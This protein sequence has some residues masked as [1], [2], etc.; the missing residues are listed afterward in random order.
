MVSS[1]QAYDSGV[2]TAGNPLAGHPWYVDRDRGSWFLA[3]RGIHA[4]AAAFSSAANN[5]MGKTF[6][7]MYVHPRQAVFNYIKRADTAEPGSIPFLNLA[8]IENPSCPYTAF[9]PGFSEKQVD[10]YIRQF[11]LGLGASRVMIILETDKLTTT[12][13]LPKWAQ[14]RRFRELSLEVSTLHRDDPNAIVY[15]D[16]G[17]WDWGKPAP[18]IARWLKRADVAQAEGFSLNT[19]HHDWTSRE[20]KFGLAISRMTGGKHFVVN[21]DSNAWGPRPHGKDFDSRYYVKGC[22]PP[23]EGLGIQPTVNTGNPL[24]DAYIWAGT[25]GY[26]TG[27]CLGYGAHSAYKFYLPLAQSLVAHARSYF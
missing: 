12:R 7:K 27:H 17:A 23:G 18:V 8:R 14:A 19:S 25:P 20:V 11:G 26:E 15:L 9:R 21:T 16:A 5:P 6:T 2:P 24:I 13:C 1:A 10:S 22:T 3:L 4:N